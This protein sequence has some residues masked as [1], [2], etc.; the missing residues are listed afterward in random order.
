MGTLYDGF[1]Y[2][3]SLYDRLYSTIEM[4]NVSFTVVDEK[5]VNESVSD[6]Y[7]F[8]SIKIDYS[9]G[10]GRTLSS[11]YNPEGLAEKIVVRVA[12]VCKLSFEDSVYSFALEKILLNE[13]RCEFSYVHDLDRDKLVIVEIKIFPKKSKSITLLDTIVDQAVRAL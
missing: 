13:A 6:Y 12:R 11:P 8:L 5:I 2:N 4:Q 3:R 7:I 10:V 9:Y 1:L